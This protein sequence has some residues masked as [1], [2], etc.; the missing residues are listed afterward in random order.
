MVPCVKHAHVH[1]TLCEV[2]TRTWYLVCKRGLRPDGQV[3]VEQGR[4]R[5]PLLMTHSVTG[6]AVLGLQRETL[7]TTVQGLPIPPAASHVSN[8]TSM[9]IPDT[10]YTSSYEASWHWGVAL[11]VRAAAH[12]A[13]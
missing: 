12:S 8:S 13:D 11:R 6:G 3:R 1:G 2:R 4:A 5:P 10:C 7:L 9:L